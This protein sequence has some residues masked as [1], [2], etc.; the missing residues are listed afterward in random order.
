MAPMEIIFAYTLAP[1]AVKASNAPPAPIT[2]VANNVRF[3]MHIPQKFVNKGLELLVAF[4]ESFPL[5]YALND[6]PIIFLPK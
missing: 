2:I 4:L 6:T 1:H 5:R 3:T